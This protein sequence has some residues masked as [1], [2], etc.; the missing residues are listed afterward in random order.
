MALQEMTMNEVKERVDPELINLIKAYAVGK[1]ALDVVVTLAA[2]MGAAI[3]ENSDSVD[4]IKGMLDS[5]KV[6]S[7]D[8]ASY[9]WARNNPN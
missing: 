2:L 1:P 3:G 9:S 8:A 6:I 4:D 5:L 7:V